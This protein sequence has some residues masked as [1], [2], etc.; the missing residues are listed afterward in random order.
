MLIG[1]SGIS[2][3]AIIGDYQIDKVVAIDKSE[4]MTAY[5]LLSL[6]KNNNFE[7]GIGTTIFVKGKWH[8]TDS[9]YGKDASMKMERQATLLFSYHGEEIVGRLRGNIVSFS[10]PNVFQKEKHLHATYVRLSE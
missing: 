6:K 8:V 9:G 4:S 10:V 3:D 7:L 2:E 1:C 5:T